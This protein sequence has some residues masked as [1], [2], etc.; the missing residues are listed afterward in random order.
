MPHQG[1]YPL[2]ISDGGGGHVSRLAADLSNEPLDRLLPPFSHP[3]LQGVELPQAITSWVASL[4]LDEK[5]KCG[6]IRI[7]LKTQHHL[8]PVVVEDIR[9][10]AAYRMAAPLSPRQHVSG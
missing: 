10:S 8:P 7:F 2:A 4:E 5:L 3:L 9:T 1:C 6:L